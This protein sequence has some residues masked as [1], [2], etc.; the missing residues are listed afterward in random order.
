MQL[1]G[2]LEE[3]FE[4]EAL[5]RCLLAAPGIRTLLEDEL[6]PERWYPSPRPIRL[7]ETL[8][9]E[10]GRGDR[11]LVAEAG[12][13]LARRTAER[14]E[15]FTPELV[16]AL[17][18]DVWKGF[19]AI[20]DIEVAKVGRGHGR[21]E[22][23]KLPDSSLALCAAIAGYLDEALRLAGGRDVDVRLVEAVALGDD[24]DVFEAT[25]SS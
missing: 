3:H 8:D 4:R 24:K 2:F 9:R 23:R 21:L 12:R 10:V 5:E 22:T 16:F 1:R 19:L 7:V 20:G 17:L 14:D 15:D 25:W 6:D 18:P 13:Y 11:A